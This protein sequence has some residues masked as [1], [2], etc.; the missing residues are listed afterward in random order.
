M[1]AERVIAIDLGGTKC[2][3]GVVDREGEIVERKI[4]PTVLTSQEELLREMEELVD[5]LMTDEIEAI[6]VGVPSVI[7][8][9]AGVAI[10]S[11]NVPLSNAPLRDRLSRRFERPVAIENDANA[12]ALGEHRFGAGRGTQHM[13]LLT[14]GTGIGGGLILN[15]ELYRGAIGAAA[16]LGHTTIDATAAIE[17]G[18]A[19]D[20]GTLER[21]GSGTAAD[22]LAKRIAAERPE[23]D[24]GRA[25][26]A[27]ETIDARLAERLARDGGADALEV[28][29]TVGSY[30]GYGIANFVDTF[31]PEMVVLGGGFSQAGAFVLE[32]ARRVVAERAFVPRSDLQIVPAILGVDAG[33]IGAAVVAFE[34]HDSAPGGTRSSHATRH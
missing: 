9:R 17:A 11:A 21:L 14:L 13:I 10:H 33:L 7:D 31:N 19:G 28:F 25:A 22:T 2:L 6:G 23:G 34:V 20:S 16:E 24:L 12:A 1:P 18:G 8:Q 5:E 4:R 15:G 29:E 3:A 26:A 30:L 27:G 32:P